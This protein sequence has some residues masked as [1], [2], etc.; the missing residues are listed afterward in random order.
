MNSDN[1]I[2]LEGGGVAARVWDKNVCGG[3]VRLRSGVVVCLI[4]A[5]GGGL[6]RLSS[7][8]FDAQQR[9]PCAP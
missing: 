7:T 9:C 4:D 3:V 1:R 5:A 8:S 6:R 2:V